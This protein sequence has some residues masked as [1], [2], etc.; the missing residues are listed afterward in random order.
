MKMLILFADHLLER[1][2]TSLLLVDQ[3]EQ[4]SH[5]LSSTKKNLLL[6]ASHFLSSTKKL[7]YQ[8]FSPAAPLHPDVP[9]ASMSSNP[10]ST[11]AP[12]SKARMPCF[13]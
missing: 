1:V 10:P 13:S 11:Q 5:F 4:A 12:K 3:G 7:F 8:K 2:R 6:Q 9:L